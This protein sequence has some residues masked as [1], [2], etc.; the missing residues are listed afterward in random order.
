V[1]RLATKA[2][3]LIGWVV[4]RLVLTPIV[5]ELAAPVAQAETRPVSQ[6]G[7][8]QTARSPSP[9][10]R[11]ARPRPG[12]RAPDNRLWLD[13]N[14]RIRLGD[15]QPGTCRKGEF[16]WRHPKDGTI[17]VSYDADMTEP[18]SGWLRL[19]FVTQN[20]KTRNRQVRNQHLRMML[21]SDGW[22][23][24]VGGCAS[25]RLSL[26]PGGNGFKCPPAPRARRKHRKHWPL[27]RRKVIAKNTTIRCAIH[28]DD[29]LRAGALVPGELRNLNLLVPVGDTKVSFRFSSDMWDPKHSRLWIYFNIHDGTKWRSVSQEVQL[30]R[31]SKQWWFKEDDRIGVELVLRDGRFRVPRCPFKP[32]RCASQHE[33]AHITNQTA[34]NPRAIT[35]RQSIAVRRSLATRRRKGGFLSKLALSKRVA[36]R[37]IARLS[38]PKRGRPHVLRWAR[39]GLDQILKPWN[40]LTGL[41]RRLMSFFASKLNNRP[42]A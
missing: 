1:K 25:S 29:L 35:A 37:F 5:A 22:Q 42:E 18:A 17:Q 11:R 3:C 40:L 38:A 9:P 30:A 10:A 12:A 6:A 8:G 41:A 13:L 34:E 39:A 20:P 23:F 32:P 31:G 19:W 14:E 26:R 28:I 27:W 15:L 21:T 4:A 24:M 2:R 7:S 16:V 33:S 36:A